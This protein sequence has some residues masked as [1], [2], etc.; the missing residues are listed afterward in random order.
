MHQ[1]IF[2]ILV[3]GSYQ[4]Q[5]RYGNDCRHSCLYP[6]KFRY[7]AL[8]LICTNVLVLTWFGQTRHL[9]ALYFLCDCASSGKVRSMSLWYDHTGNSTFSKQQHTPKREMGLRFFRYC[10][11]TLSEINQ[12][13]FCRIH[14]ALLRFFDYFNMTLRA[15]NCIR[16]LC[17]FCCFWY[18]ILASNVMAV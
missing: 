18:F 6:I 13:D 16:S 12:R 10:E 17:L 9:K 3:L 11:R 4:T 2:E 1:H 15:T 14:Y 7:R 5:L 8:L